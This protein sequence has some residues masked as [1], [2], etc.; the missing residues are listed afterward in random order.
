MVTILLVVMIVG[1]LIIIGLFVMRLGLP[2]PVDATSLALPE[3][4]S[5]TS[6]TQGQTWQAIVG[7][8]NNIYL[9]DL[10]GTLFQTVTIE[11][12]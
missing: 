9:F 6:F 2:S 3:G 8:D 11:Q 7:D 5:A 10:K 1:F 12:P 4:V